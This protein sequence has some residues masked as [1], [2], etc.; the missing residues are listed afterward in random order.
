[1]VN[2]DYAGRYCRD[3]DVDEHDYG[4]NLS[5]KYGGSDDLVIIIMTTML[6][7]NHVHS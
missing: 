6:Q 3:V 4:F 2:N 7:I 5:Y 1:M